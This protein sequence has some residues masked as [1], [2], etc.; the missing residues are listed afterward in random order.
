MSDLP[1]GINHEV[2]EPLYAWDE[3]A[4][5][6]HTERAGRAMSRAHRLQP[7]LQ[8]FTRTLTK[9]PTITLKMGGFGASFTD[10]K[11]VWITPPLELGDVHQHQRA[12]C[13]S[14]DS[15]G[16]V[17]CEGCQAMESLMRTAEHEIGHITGG[18]FVPVDPEDVEAMIE[19]AAQRLCE[20]NPAQGLSESEW[21][22][23]IRDAIERAN[24][25]AKSGHRK[26]EPLGN[27]MALAR[28]VS[29]WLPLLL[30]ALEDAR[31]NEQI[32]QA[33]PG[34]RRYFK[35]STL[36]LLREGIHTLD[37]QHL[38]YRDRDLS[39]Q[40]AIAG[41]LVASG[42]VDDGMDLAEFFKQEV[43]D[44]Y[45]GKE[46]R[47]TL[48][49]ASR[50]PSGMRTYRLANRFLRQIQEHGF[51]PD[52]PASIG[53][54]DA[55]QS[56]ALALEVDAEP[57]QD[58]DPSEANNGSE[59][60][61]RGESE[62]SD[63]G[64]SAPSDEPDSPQDNRNSEP[65]DQ[66]ESGPNEEKDSEPGDPTDEPDD[67][68]GTAAEQG[69]DDDSRGRQ[70]ED[71]HDD[72]APTPLGDDTDD[73][74]AGSQIEAEEPQ[75]GPEQDSDSEDATGEGEG[76]GGAPEDLDDEGGDPGP[77]GGDG[78]QPDG[79]GATD[80]DR[81]Q[82]ESPS[83]ADEGP[84]AGSGMDASDQPGSP[85]D[86]SADGGPRGGDD[87][88][89]HDYHHDEHDDVSEREGHQG[90]GSQPPESQDGELAQGDAADPDDDL[91]EQEPGPTAAE[92]EQEARRALAD[93]K[94][95]SGHE[96]ELDELR[97]DWSE[98]DGDDP[99][100]IDYEVDGDLPAN[101][102]RD[103]YGSPDA[104][105][106]QGSQTM[107]RA[108]SQHE[109]FRTGSFEV[110]KVN[111][112]RFGE[113]RGR[114]GDR[115]SKRYLDRIYDTYRDLKAG[116]GIGE[117]R[118]YWA[119]YEPEELEGVARSCLNQARLAFT[120]NQVTR[121]TRNQPVGRLYT[122]TMGRKLKTGDVKV[123]GRKQR[124]NNR[125]YAVLVGFDISGST[126]NGVL[127]EIKRAV[128]AQA[129]LV[130]RLGI[131]FGIFAHTSVSVTDHSALSGGR[132][133][134]L[135]I[136]VVKD[137]NEPWNA[138]AKLRMQAVQPAA[139]NL[140]GH[141]MEVYRKL[142]ERQKA[143][144]RVLL[145]YTDGAMPAANYDEEKVVLEREVAEM[146]RDPHWI[147]QAAGIGT[148]SPTE[149]GLDTTVVEEP[150]DLKKVVQDLQKKLVL[151]T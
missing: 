109:F 151:V 88:S 5:Q 128:H 1:M 38:E 52:P 110:G 101:S 61:D 21:A 74:A 8:A 93:F 70:D 135:D 116:E 33:R 35:A 131:D 112:L 89:D 14:Y 141:T 54:G 90:L 4:R 17:L 28:F 26:Y 97:Q 13:N 92:I 59:R 20:A 42:Y 138:E 130:H 57:D 72:P 23:K 82:L 87:H 64:D 67:E 6:A 66:H 7:G 139:N 71:P 105:W 43:A 136:I 148:D 12:L 95:A 122:P 69:A 144:H 55:A 10:G 44:L 76:D 126:G 16:Q 96:D 102:T 46:I 41:F 140:D 99:D 143:T 137:F 125:D 3:Q 119:D 73:D 29:P 15:D 24:D 124:P 62:Q 134:D 113:S 123:F 34:S 100:D 129:E 133:H 107:E 142:L 149:Y 36:K 121:R 53:E 22:S 31:V 85:G 11:G 60:A 86:P 117:S 68:A 111:L 115:W 118:Q 78:E 50:S 132:S 47:K 25:E 37:G 63:T 83:E 98:L 145:Y 19:V 18:S 65:E 106:D 146:Q 77:C 120:E 114:K 79:D 48:T 51:L 81:Q 84:S 75:A 32:H 49:D 147:L 91:V 150:A 45:S 40:I 2:D 80:A 58:T 56:A 103:D 9:D 104:G 108:H 27:Y 127:L 30:N 39:T 94:V